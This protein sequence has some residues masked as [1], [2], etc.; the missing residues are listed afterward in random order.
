M[1]LWLFTPLLK[2]KE[3][4]R[5]SMLSFHSERTWVQIRPNAGLTSTRCLACTVQCLGL[6]AQ[7]NPAPSQ[8]FCIASLH[9]RP[10]RMPPVT[11]E[12]LSLTLMGNTRS[13]ERRVGKECVS[14]CRTRWSPYHKKKKK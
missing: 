4:M 10:K 6:Q 7:A 1:R 5:S 2:D 11:R 14:T 3:K 13:E 8:P 9:T 12:L